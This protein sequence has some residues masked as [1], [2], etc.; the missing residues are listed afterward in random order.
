MKR[1][2]TTF[3]IPENLD[4]TWVREYVENALHSEGGNYNPEHPYFQLCRILR[5]TE[6]TTN[7]GEVIAPKPNTRPILGQRCIVRDRQPYI[8][9]VIAVI[10]GAAGNDFIRVRHAITKVEQNFAP[11]SLDLLPP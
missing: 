7:E 3:D 5:L 11:S 8:G 2:T 10:D 9:V 4:I 6:I 1:I